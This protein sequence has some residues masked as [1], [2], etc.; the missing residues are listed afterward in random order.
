MC[1]PFLI[2][3]IICLSSALPHVI[4]NPEMSVLFHYRFAR[5]SHFAYICIQSHILLLQSKPHPRAI[6]L[7]FGALISITFSSKDMKFP[8]VDFRY[9][10][11]IVSDNMLAGFCQFWLYSVILHFKIHRIMYNEATQI[12]QRSFEL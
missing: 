7:F 6:L 10:K 11:L 9:S 8:P 12:Y 3:G 5:P 2:V 1:C 4:Y